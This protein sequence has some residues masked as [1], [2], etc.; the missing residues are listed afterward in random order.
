MTAVS[1]AFELLSGE[2]MSLRRRSE[3]RDLVQT[4][5]GV[6]GLANPEDFLREIDTVQT[7]P[8][9]DE[10]VIIYPAAHDVRGQQQ[11]TFEGEE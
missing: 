5:L 8:Y 11:F 2:R 9:A 6:I 1:S 3:L 10:P 7:G 4:H